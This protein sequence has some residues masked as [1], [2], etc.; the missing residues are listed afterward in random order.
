MRYLTKNEEQANLDAYCKHNKLY[1]LRE[2]KKLTFFS[3]DNGMVLSYCTPREAW[4]GAK[5]AVARLRAH[6]RVMS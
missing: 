6:T 2:K 4:A 1:L 5:R 3:L